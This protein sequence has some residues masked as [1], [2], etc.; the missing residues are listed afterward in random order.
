MPFALR[1][2]SGGCGAG[3]AKAGAGRWLLTNLGIR[4]GPLDRHDPVMATNPLDPPCPCRS[5]RLLASCCAAVTGG[6]YGDED[7]D[8]ALRELVRYS[9]RGE[10]A[11]AIRRTAEAMA[12][13]LDEEA[14][15]YLS[16]HFD[17]DRKLM[18]LYAACTERP[19]R[20]GDS[21][22]TLL[23]RKE[24]S[25]QPA[26]VRALLAQWA[27]QPFSLYEVLEVF[28]DQGV[29][30]RDHLR[31]FTVR[32]AE[33]T[34]TRQIR[35]GWW[36]AVRVRIRP[37]GTPVMDP[38][39]LA[40]PPGARQ[41]IDEWLDEV[42]DDQP[43]DPRE[44]AID[45]FH[46][47]EMS[48]AE[49]IGQPAPELV[50]QHGDRVVLCEAEF[51]VADGEAMA[52]ALA[53]H[54]DWDLDESAEG[55]DRCWNWFEPLEDD[56]R[57][58][59]GRLQLQGNA[60]VLKVS[61]RERLDRARSV[62][63]SIAGVEFVAVTET[64]PRQAED[65]DDDESDDTA[66]PALDVDREEVVRQAMDRHYRKWVDES[67]PMFGGRTAR[68]MAKIDPAAVSRAIWSIIH[69]ANGGLRYDASWM[70]AELGVPRLGEG[71][72][73]AGVVGG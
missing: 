73:E 13:P 59:L 33:V 38:P 24:G 22:A 7:V 2:R 20:G 14:D 46:L 57:R 5:G 44:H 63:E 11:A 54:P 15:D 61:S 53:A 40:F 1:Q 35:P 37:D 16:E 17:L 51:R 41:A 34:G 68:Q 31:L 23:V 28:E 29:V 12:A 19:A 43:I 60:A 56:F 30:L 45:L 50:D 25:R 32:V 26:R 4:N 65:Q 9:G 62:L 8:V 58:L 27:A 55:A 49:A 69:G 6:E 70:Y 67:V 3:G 21:V 48:V 66:A 72:F 42:V 64:D 39:I 71:P 52:A 47:W 18:C 10:F 36:M